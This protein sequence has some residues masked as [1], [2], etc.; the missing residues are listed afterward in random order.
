MRILVAGGGT[1]GLAT[2]VALGSRGHHVLVLERRP[3]FTENGM[4]VRL[5]PPAFRLLDRL[6]VGA[7]VRRRSLAI[8]EI[9]IM[10]GSTGERVATVP[11]PGR[12]GGTPHAPHATAHRLD[13]YEPLLDAC[14]QLDVVRLR[15]DS[16]VVGYTERGESVV[17]ALVGGRSVTGDALILTD[18]ARSAAR[19]DTSWTGGAPEERV[20]VYRTVVPM[21]LV[22][23]R[24]QD[25]AAISWVGAQWHV[26][27]Y[28]LPD[29]RYLSL[30]ATRHRHTGGDL[31]G[32]HL[33]LGHVLAAF[34]D[35]GYAAR[36]VLTMGR[37][38]RAWTVPGRR[39]AS[40]RA[41]GRVALVGETAEP[42]LPVEVSGVHQALE[43]ADGLGR[44]WDASDGDV[45]RWLADYAT[46]RS[47]ERFPDAHT[48]C[49]AGGR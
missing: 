44:S 15:A 32:A 43:D 3:V 11:L 34:P 41:R 38:W 19:D 40:A 13:V 2:A 21:E 1:S 24:W 46:R 16:G 14:W 22:A 29:S 42:A 12:H 35:I 36:D 31:T 5:T 39:T 10:D 28:P 37:Q 45:R 17:A 27:H 25:S 4:G 30:S 6:G 20:A 9:R 49:G 23:N 33:D 47:G 26:S 7:A 18:S 8:G 48:G